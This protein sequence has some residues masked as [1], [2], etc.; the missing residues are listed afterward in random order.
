MPNPESLHLAKGSLIDAERLAPACEEATR[1]VEATVDDYQAIDI[2]LDRIREAAPHGIIFPSV[3]VREHQR[4]WLVSQRGYRTVPDGLTFTRGVIGRSVRTGSVQFVR[5]VDG[6]GDYIQGVQGIVCELAIPLGGGRPASGVFNIESR[7]PVAPDA[8]E[9]LTEFSSCLGPRVEAI[10][11]APSLDVPALARLFVHSS[12]L[13]EVSAIAEL[14][15]RS[16]GRLLDL[17]SAQLNVGRPG[18]GSRLAG[19]WRMADSQLEPIASGL[20]DQIR[21]LARPSAVYDLLDLGTTTVR[22]AVGRRRR[23]VALLPLRVSGVEM[24]VLVGCSENPITFERG[25]VEVATL[26]AAHAAASIDAVQALARERRAAVTDPLTGLL[27]RRGF[28]DRF[29][30]EL[31]RAQRSER[32][33]AVAVF[34]C[35]DFKAINDGGGHELGDEALRAV[36]EFLSTATRSWDVAARLGGDEFVLVLP[37]VGG[38]EA[39]G[40]AERLRK[41]LT[42]ESRKAGYVLAA[43]MGVAVFPDDG[44]TTSDL[45]R[46]ADQAMYRAKESGK[47]RTIAYAELRARPA[48]DGLMDSMLD[49]ARALDGGYLFD[50]AHS[51]VVGECAQ[52]LAGRLGL[53]SREADRVRLAGLLHDI[54]KAGLPES[55]LRKPGPLTESEWVE[56][57]KHPIIGAHMVERAREEDIRRWIRWHHERPDGRGYPDGLSGEEIPLQA[58]IL[59][60]ADAYEAM[61]STR[62]YRPELTREEALAELRRNAGTQFDA[63]VV[64]ALAQLVADGLLAERP[65]A[66]TKAALALPTLRTRA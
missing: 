48:G 34:D 14:A 13:R 12:S 53:D 65:V 11:S 40:V 50:H 23:H 36:A 6:D 24:G 51:R 46:A 62:P 47:G 28:D 41:G 8:H 56:V 37:E 10:R 44:D 43:S 30:E 31:D 61:T 18:E 9:L 58:R 52:L 38:A 45:L 3:F 22:R 25:Q 57:R 26:L 19:Y 49:V 39:T 4:L 7:L 16:L 21:A 32:P 54:G 33:L 35:D 63:N 55:I 59:A 1:L 17:E 27:N 5:N 66:E 20:L 60:V 2:A 15:A 64:E 42:R 29:Q